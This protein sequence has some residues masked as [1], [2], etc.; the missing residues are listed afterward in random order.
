MG[1][2]INTLAFT[3]SHKR[4]VAREEKRASV[5]GDGRKI[6]K[7][8]NNNI[9]SFLFFCAGWNEQKKNNLEKFSDFLLK[10][11]KKFVYVQLLSDKFSVYCLL[12]FRQIYWFQNAF[13][14]FNTFST[15]WEFSS[16]NNTKRHW[17]SLLI[18]PSR[19]QIDSLLF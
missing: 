19:Y 18:I 14:N 15:L 6:H 7:W 11:C 9:H 17:Y 16:E 13:L 10:G 3:F 1:V 2:S 5:W 8:G 12:I 4:I